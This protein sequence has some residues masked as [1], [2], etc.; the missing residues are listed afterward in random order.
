[1]PTLMSV[2]ILLFTNIE[3]VN[4]GMLLGKISNIQGLVSRK[5]LFGK[6]GLII[7]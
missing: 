6:Y 5:K 1:M 4:S 3:N 7:T 2:H